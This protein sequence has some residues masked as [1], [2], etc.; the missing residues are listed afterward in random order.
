VNINTSRLQKQIGELAGL[1]DNTGPGVTRVIFSDADMQART[2]VKRLASNLDLRVR[3]DGAGNLFM[4]WDGSEPEKRPVATG[5]HIDAI[6]HAGKFDGVVGVLGALEAVRCLQEDSYRP[7]RSIEVIS[8]TSEEPTRFGIGCLGSRILSG[9]LSAPCAS[10]LKDD[11]GV[12]LGEWLQRRGFA[13]NTL[14]SAR[15]VNG[16]YDAFVELHIEQGPRL[17]AE[18]LDIGIVDRIA[19]PSTTRVVL[20][21]AG[22]H[23]GAVMMSR[24]NDALAAAGEILL[25][26]ERVAVES[27]SPHTVATVG[28][29]ENFP[30]AVNSIPREVLLEIDLRGT[31]PGVWQC[32]LETLT[33][34]IDEISARRHVDCTVTRLNE[35]PPAVCDPKLVSQ[36]RDLSASLGHSHKVLP[37]HAYHDSLFMAQL[38]PTGMIFVPSR[39]GISHTPEEYSTPEQI[40]KG[41]AMLA[42]ILRVWSEK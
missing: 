32:A 3:E 31:D 11:D 22:G 20:S 38:C 6:P 37:S 19:G 1:S 26:A 28:K 34:E 40:Q 36:L 23:A 39:D 10:A 15:L 4:R 7:H 17:E 27:E 2:V 8:F 18:E 21:G 13:E 35:D 41:V 29:L 30:N 24:R 33:G 12:T 16:V 14:D 9:S 5:S 42:G 25:A